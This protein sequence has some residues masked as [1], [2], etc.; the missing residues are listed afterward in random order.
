MNYLISAAN[1][2]I[3]ISMARILKQEKNDTNIIGVAPDGIY[4]A[5]NYFDKVEV[6][7]YAADVNYFNKLLFYIQSYKINVFIPVSEAELSFFLNNRDLFSTQLDVKILINNPYMPKLMYEADLSIGASG[8]SVWE[9]C[10]LG[11][12]SVLYLTADNQNLFYNTLIDREI[13]YSKNMLSTVLKTP[14]QLLSKVDNYCD[15]LGIS[16]VIKNILF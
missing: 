7:P 1:S 9:R 3:A 14:Y 13:C 12:P 6:I 5:L 16:R 15:G 10:Y 8:S 4:P 11:L 2:D